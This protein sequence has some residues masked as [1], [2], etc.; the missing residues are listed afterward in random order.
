[1]NTKQKKQRFKTMAWAF[2]IAWGI[3]HWTMLLWFFVCGALAVLPAVALRFNRDTLSILSGFLSGAP[4]TYADVV[5]PIV[6]LGLL[7]IAIGLSAR[8]NSQF[9]RMMT[10][11]S[12]FGGM[13]A[14]IMEH[15]QDID[16]KDLLRKEVNDMW[17]S[18]ILEGNSLWAFVEGL[19]FIFSK[20]VGI[21]ALLITAWSMSVPVFLASA[22]YVAVIFIISLAFSKETRRNQTEDFNDER[23]IEY[24]ERMSENRGM[25]KETRLFENTD[26][27]IKQWKQPYL[28]IQKRDLRRAKAAELRDFITGAGFYAFL[29]VAIGVSIAAVAKGSMRPDALLVIFTL[30]LNLLNT[31]SGTA[32][33]IVKFDFGLIALDKQRRFF[34][35]VKPHPDGTEDTPADPETVFDVRDL[36]F[37]YRDSLAIDGVSFQVKRGEVVALVGANGSGK[38]TLVKLLLNMYKPDSGSVRFFGRPYGEYRRDYI[39]SRL[40]VFFQDFYLFHSSLGENIGVGAVEHMEDMDMIREALRKGGAEKVATN[41]PKGLDTL[42]GKFQDK[43]GSELSG[44]EKQR[45]ASARTHMAD[46]DVLIFDEPASM[47]DPI[48]EMEQFLGIKNLLKG[49]TAI[50]ISHRVGFARMADKIIMLDGGKIAEMGSHEELMALNGRYAHFF[51]EQAQWYGVSQ[52]TVNGGAAE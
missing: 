35:L 21:T 25:A 48:A 30:C 41:L 36:C 38:S 2:R 37:S 33:Y 31:I 42:L 39:R 20:L 15:V 23:Q 17:M 10:Y 26:Q 51:N 45:V 27:V 46:R 52:T 11:D 32:R 50:L 7:M 13:Y 28:R 3:D 29:I 6:K 40:S 44:G 9:V 19:C 18:A 8:V 49:R 24:Y 34:E 5:K 47:L 14:Y 43:S 12:Y 16:M 22:V 4:Y 1:M